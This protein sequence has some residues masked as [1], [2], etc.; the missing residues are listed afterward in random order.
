[1]RNIYIANGLDHGRCGYT[2]WSPGRLFYWCERRNLVQW[3][4]VN[5]TVHIVCKDV[6]THVPGEKTEK[7]KTIHLSAISSTMFGSFDI[8]HWCLYVWLIDEKSWLVW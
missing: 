1:M 8:F 3:D 4:S 2:K 7:L 6:L 5:V